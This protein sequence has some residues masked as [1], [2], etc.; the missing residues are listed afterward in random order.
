VT[1]HIEFGH[2]TD[3]TLAGVGDGILESDMNDRVALSLG[4]R[5]SRPFRMPLVGAG[6][7]LP[8]VAQVARRRGMRTTALPGTSR[9]GRASG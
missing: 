5:A 6:D 2:N 9:S 7:V 1:G 3:A 8:P 4:N